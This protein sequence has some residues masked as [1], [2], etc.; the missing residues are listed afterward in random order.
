M[1][2]GAGN[3]STAN[4]YNPRVHPLSNSTNLSPLTHGDILLS[5]GSE[6]DF[7][8]KKNLQMLV[9]DTFQNSGAKTSKH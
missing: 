5:S 6:T 7:K 1:Q 4:N 8:A 9:Q 3:L 2:C